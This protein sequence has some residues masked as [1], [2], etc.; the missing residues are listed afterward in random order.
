[1]N[2]RNSLV[3]GIIRGFLRVFIHANTPCKADAA[4]KLPYP[5]P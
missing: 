4:E 1:M 3:K 5:R 2:S